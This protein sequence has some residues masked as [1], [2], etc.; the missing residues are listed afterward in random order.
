[1]SG[2]SVKI[3]SIQM[4]AM[5]DELAG[6]MDDLTPVMQTI[7]EIIV[8]QTDTAFETG[9]APDGTAW[10][11]SGRAQATGGQTLIDTAVLRNSINVLATDNQVEVGTNVLYAAIHQLGGKAGRGKKTV[12]PSRPFLPDQ[13]S[14]DWPEVKA[15]LQDFLE[16][17]L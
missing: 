12:I 13:D 10:P 11:A 1:M 15:T 7:G 17:A 14:L 5:L 6:R 4:E 2:L 3:E 16:G 9:V 8:E